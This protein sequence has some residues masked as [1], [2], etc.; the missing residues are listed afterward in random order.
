[1][2]V[3]VNTATAYRINRIGDPPGLIRQGSTSAAWRSRTLRPWDPWLC[4]PA[5]RRVCPYRIEALCWRVDQLCFH[6]VPWAPAGLQERWAILLGA[7][8]YP[9]GPR[10]PFLGLWACCPSGQ[11]PGRVRAGNGGPGSAGGRG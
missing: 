4:A 2:Q 9:H 6:H 10:G 8:A 11:G 5:S 7:E 3:T 1:M